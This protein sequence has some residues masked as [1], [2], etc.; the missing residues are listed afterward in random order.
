MRS[1]AW[2]PCTD[3]VSGLWPEMGKNG[4]KNGSWPHRQNGAKMAEKWENWPKQG[5]EKLLRFA[6]AVLSFL[7]VFGFRNSIPPNS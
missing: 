2:L 1:W 5:P 3:P 4:R 7:G 6:N